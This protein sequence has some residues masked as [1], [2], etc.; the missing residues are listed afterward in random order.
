VTAPDLDLAPALR[1]ALIGEPTIA[2]P[3]SEWQNE[4][5]VFTRRP[6]P[7]D[8]A[9]PMIIVN[10]PA[11]IGDDDG[12][13]SDRPVVQLD[14]AIYGKKA[15]PGDASDQTRIVEA[16]GFRVRDLFHRQKFAILPDGFS[17]IGITAAGPFPAPVDDEE[18]VGRLVSLTIR[19]RRKP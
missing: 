11:A 9:D 13:T 19:L 18:T 4:P 7:K 6:V 8:A 5:A 1:A 16:L 3:L 2:D 15:A 14:I 10:P 17:V 12:L